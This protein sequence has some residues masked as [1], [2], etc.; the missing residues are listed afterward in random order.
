[1]TSE[2]YWTREIVKLMG[3][4]PEAIGVLLVAQMPIPKHRVAGVYYVRGATGGK[5][6][7]SR[8]ERYQR[9]P[10]PPALRADAPGGV[11]RDYQIESGA[12]VEALRA[13]AAG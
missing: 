10:H 6:C 3:K 4:H 12:A 11:V 7:K 13:L 9:L 5:W 1:M 2:Q 8:M